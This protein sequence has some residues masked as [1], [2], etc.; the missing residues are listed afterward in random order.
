MPTYIIDRL[1]TILLPRVD[2]LL[3]AELGGDST[4]KDP[5]RSKRAR[6]WIITAIGTFDDC[7]RQACHHAAGLAVSTTTF[8]GRTTRPETYLRYYRTALHHPMTLEQA[9]RQGYKLRT[10]IRFTE[11]NKL[12][13]Q[14]AALSR[15]KQ[16]QIVKTLGSSLTVFDF[17]VPEDLVAW[18]AHLLP[19]A[20]DNAELTGPGATPIAESGV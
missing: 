20:W 3:A 14:Y 9:I 11:A 7:M 12:P 1:E 8:R 19:N 15:I 2:L 4:I 17:G 6:A 10:M 13:W 16:P 5:V 18:A